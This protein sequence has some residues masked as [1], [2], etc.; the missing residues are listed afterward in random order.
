MSLSDTLSV[1][2]GVRQGSILGPSL[3]N[4]FINLIIVNLRKSH[5]GCV[6]NR[7]D[8]GC[9]MHTDDLISAS[10]AGLE[11][12]LTNCLHTCSQLSM[13]LNASKS[14][15]VYF[16]T[17]YNADVDDHMLGNAKITRNSSFKYLGI[18][19]I[20]GKSIGVNIEPI[21]YNYFMSCN[22][23][24]SH[25]SS[26]CDLVQLQLHESYVLPTLTYATAAIKCLKRR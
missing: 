3:F 19:F 1:R 16:G 25:A 9:C 20:N 13:S 12:T 6:I 11:A 17:R 23:I 10:P 8:L 4:I 5:T 24:V 7:T 2:S 15:C 26:R 21:R 14:C 18:H 22:N